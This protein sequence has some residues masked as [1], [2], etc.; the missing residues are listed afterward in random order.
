MYWGAMVIAV[1]TLVLDNVT[2]AG[3]REG[4]ISEA[5]VNGRMHTPSAVLGCKWR[6]QCGFIQMS[7]SH[8]TYGL[9]FQGHG[10]AAR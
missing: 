3:R 5:S 1:L 2:P 7:A 10:L 8:V 4:S 9:L 6:E